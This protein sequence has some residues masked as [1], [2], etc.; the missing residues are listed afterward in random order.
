MFGSLAE[1]SEGPG[2]AQA[3]CGSYAMQT[4]H[5]AVPDST[6]TAAEQGKPHLPELGLT[7]QIYR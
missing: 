4:R 3:H 6:H 1:H 7:I 5:A 2:Q